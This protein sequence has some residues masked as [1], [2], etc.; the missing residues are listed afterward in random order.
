[1][2]QSVGKTPAGRPGEA[3]LRAATLDGDALEV[4]RLFG[5]IQDPL[6]K[7]AVLDLLRS[8]AQPSARAAPAILAF[9]LPDRRNHD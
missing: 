4:C 8:V 2:V 1:M 7:E 3:E 6:V 9:P 5:Q